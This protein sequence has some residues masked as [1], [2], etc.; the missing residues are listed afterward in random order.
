MKHLIF[1]YGSLI[2]QDNLIKFNS[3]II[4]SVFIKD[5]HLDIIKSPI[6]KTNYHYIQLNQITEW[7]DDSVGNS[8][9]PGFLIET[10]N[11][12]AID[13]WEGN[14]YKRIETFCYDRY[15]NEIKC[16]VYIKK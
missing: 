13:K 2:L 3:E 6:T 14:S 8:I 16:F 9:I 10:S 4:T 1:S 5:F 12:E 15:M 11:I 7:D